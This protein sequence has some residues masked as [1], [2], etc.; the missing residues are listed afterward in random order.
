MLHISAPEKAWLTCVLWQNIFCSFSWPEKQCCL[1]ISPPQRAWL[2]WVL[3]QN[4]FCSFSWPE[5]QCSAPYLRSWV[6]LTNLCPLAEYILLH[7]VTRETVSCCVSLLLSRPAEVEIFSEPFSKLSFL[8]HLLIKR[9]V[10]PSSSPTQKRKENILLPLQIFRIYKDK[11]RY[12]VMNEWIGET[13]FVVHLFLPRVMVG[14]APGH[15][16]RCWGSST[17]YQGSQEDHCK[18]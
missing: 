17:G 2:T 10:S 9:P 8:S 16:C 1:R 14:L 4:I 3:R 15:A 6:G 13:L 18:K 7:H 11:N 12:E 5:K